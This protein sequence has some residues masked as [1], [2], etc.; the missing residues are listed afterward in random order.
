MLLSE[1]G[2]R[3]FI[4]T[5]DGIIYI[6]K[7]VF[8]YIN[9]KTEHKYTNHEENR[10]TNYTRNKN[11]NKKNRTGINRPYG[12]H[13]FSPQARS[14]IRVLKSEFRKLAQMYHPDNFDGSPEIFVEIQ[15]ERVE[16]LCNLGSK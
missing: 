7:T 8:D 13:W 14:D 3:V 4:S 5:Y 2:D 9:G 12:E 10:N 11:R 15:N 1:N 16:I 6:S